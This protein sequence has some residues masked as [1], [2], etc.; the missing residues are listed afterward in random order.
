MADSIVFFALA[1]VLF[2][3]VAVLWFIF[4]FHHAPQ[5]NVDK[6][7]KKWLEIERNLSRDDIRSCQM[8]VIEAD[9][10]LDSALKERGFSGETMGERMKSAKDIWSN[11]NSVWQAHKLRNKIVHESDVQAG[12]SV[13][14]QALASFKRAL[15]DVGAI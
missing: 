14:R 8:A 7:R 13:F 9:R 11:Q 3:A 6:Y 5:L 12:Y 1:G 10:L 15:K 2:F 4:R